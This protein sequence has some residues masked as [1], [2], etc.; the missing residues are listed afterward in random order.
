MEYNQWIEDRFTL[1]IRVIAVSSGE[2]HPACV[3]TS[4]GYYSGWTG[5]TYQVG[6]DLI[7]ASRSGPSDRD[8]LD[9]G[10]LKNFTRLRLRGK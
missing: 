7:C 4:F 2:F 5:W 8:R 3:S 1:D 6:V 9:S 10:V